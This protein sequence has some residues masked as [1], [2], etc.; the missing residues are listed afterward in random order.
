MN[1]DWD[2]LQTQIRA[3]DCHLT[4][5]CHHHLV[6]ITGSRIVITERRGEWVHPSFVGERSEREGVTGPGSGDLHLKQISVIYC[7]ETWFTRGL[8][9]G[10]ADARLDCSSH[11]STLQQTRLMGINMPELKKGKGWIQPRA[12][13]TAG[14]VRMSRKLWGIFKELCLLWQKILSCFIHRPCI[15]R[16]LWLFRRG[17]KQTSWIKMLDCETGPGRWQQS[18]GK[19]PIRGHY[20]GPTPR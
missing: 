17:K 10:P 13:N 16:A 7:G 20:E 5:M 14:C 9:R 2:H 4:R 6:S 1:T 8:S 3:S 11:Q 12:E 19:Q 15:A 18:A